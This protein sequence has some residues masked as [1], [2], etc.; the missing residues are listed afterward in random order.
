MYTHAMAFRDYKSFSEG[1]IYH[2]YNRGNGR[3]DI[4]RDE[5]DYR[6]FLKRLRL[7]LG[8]PLEVQQS[9]RIRL[10]P[11]ATDDF[12]FF[13][14][15]LMPNHW[16]FL[17]RQNGAVPISGLVLRLCTSYAKY[18]N[19]KYSHVGHIF[20]DQFSSVHVADDA[21]LNAVSAY[22]HQNPKVGKQV[23]NIH[24]WK[25]SSYNEYRH[26]VSDICDVERALEVMNQT[27]SD[28]LHFFDE[29]YEELLERSAIRKEFKQLA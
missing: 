11:F 25:F 13:A 20:Q 22:I 28:Y 23:S 4:F 29:R 5:E 6:Q 15:C 12:T 7:V 14:Y 17:V 2:L 1:E 21:Q 19:K 8:K 24:D 16:H 10:T 26:S 27:H 9:E 3:M 18:F